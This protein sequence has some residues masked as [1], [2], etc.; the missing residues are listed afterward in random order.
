MGG[1]RNFGGVAPR[2]F[3]G[4]FNR[5][6]NHNF[7]HELSRFG[8]NHRFDRDFDGRFN[9]RFNRF[10]FSPLGFGF[11]PWYYGGFGS[12]LDYGLL[13][14]YG[15]YG[16]DGFGGDDGYGY[17]GYGSASYA[18]ASN[19]LYTPNEDYSVIPP[20]RS[21]QALSPTDVLFYVHVPADAEVSVNGARSTQ[22]EE[23]REYASTSLQ[24]DKTYTYSFRARWL[25]NGRQ[26]DETRKLRVTGGEVRNVDFA[27]PPGP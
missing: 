21:G 3:N 24:P 2:T 11:Y 27:Q 22:T 14:G 9:H 13:G 16:L 12:L 23:V 10:G 25:Q 6:F 17:S 20:Q 19:G 15:G 4:G 26:I 8:N 18:P 1:I 5:G 7:N